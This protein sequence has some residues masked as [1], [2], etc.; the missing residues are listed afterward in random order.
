MRTP[1][2]S[3]LFALTIPVLGATIFAV[4]AQ[5]QEPSRPLEAAGVV[6][7]TTPIGDLALAASIDPGAPQRAAVDI[8]AGDESAELPT[9]VSSPVPVVSSPVPTVPVVSSPVPV[10]AGP[11]IDSVESIL[12]DSTIRS[13]LSASGSVAAAE[14]RMGPLPSASDPVN[15]KSRSTRSTSKAKRTARPAATRPAATRSAP[16]SVAVSYA[17]GSGAEAAIIRRESGG[18]TTAKN[19]RS[20]AFGLG[21]LTIGNRVKY[22]SR[23]GSGASTTSRPAQ[24]C[25]LRS[26]IRDRYGSAARALAF[27][28]RHGWY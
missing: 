1:T 9:T 12:G 16:S 17:G 13:A 23:C 6:A 3:I 28:R 18:R 26:Y 25:M 27:H 11:A 21:Q 15:T 24:M 10:V 7:T 4:S 19:P 5:S 2:R 20:T 14:F 22:G 8:A